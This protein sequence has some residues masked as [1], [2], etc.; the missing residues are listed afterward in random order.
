[1]MLTFRGTPAHMRA[2]FSSGTMEVKKNQHIS[3]GTRKEQSTVHSISKKN[4]FP[5]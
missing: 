5:Q 4:I 2:D 3:D 1:M